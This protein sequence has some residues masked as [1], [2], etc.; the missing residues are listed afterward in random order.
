MPD[1]VTGIIQLANLLQRKLAPVFEKSKITPQQW[2]VLSVLSEDDAPATLV[3]LA[4]RLVVTKQNMTGM[5]A[6][7][8]ALGLVERQDDPNDLRSSRVQLTRRGRA[9]V[10][11]VRPAYDQWVKELGDVQALTRTAQRL[12]AE[13]DEAAPAARKRGE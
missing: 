2:A 5:M 8:E 9:L 11:K 1:A 12:I 10:D 3:G 7:L 4:R 6:R 13:L